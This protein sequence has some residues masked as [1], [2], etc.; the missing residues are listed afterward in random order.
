MNIVAF[1]AFYSDDTNA[2]KLWTP[3]QHD[4]QLVDVML[5]CMLALPHFLTDFIVDTGHCLPHVLH[6]KLTEHI[7]GEESQLPQ[8]E[9][10]LILNWCLA[11][12]QTMRT[13]IAYCN[14][15]QL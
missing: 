2:N 6:K 9:W 7:D 3:G 14:W 12:S 11:A 8:N 5:L 13:G 4:A 1:R 15:S 10:Q